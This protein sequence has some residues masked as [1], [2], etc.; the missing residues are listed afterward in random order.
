MLLRPENQCGIVSSGCPI[1]RHTGLSALITSVSSHHLVKVLSGLLHCMVSDWFSLSVCEVTLKTS[2][3]FW[4]SSYF[5]QL[6]LFRG[7]YDRLTIFY[8]KKVYIFP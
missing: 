4:S 1:W 2:Y 6:G 7:F 8:F 3:I 5:P